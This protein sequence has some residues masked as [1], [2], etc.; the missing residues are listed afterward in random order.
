MDR[1]YAMQ[2]AQETLWIHLH[3]EIDLTRRPDL[4][5]LAEAYRESEARHVVIDLGDVTFFDTTGLALI[6]RLRQ[7]AR[8]RAGQI[9]LR[10]VPPLPLRVIQIAGMGEL[11][12]DRPPATWPPLHDTDV[13]ALAGFTSK[14]LSAGQ[15]AF[16]RVVS[17]SR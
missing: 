16:A 7:E 11:L 5:R 10:N 15:G 13:A 12:S 2:L 9:V 4:H 17:P 14:R 8:P 6:A 3:G 1:C